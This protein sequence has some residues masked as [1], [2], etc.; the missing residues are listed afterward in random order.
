MDKAQ[1]QY[2]V[3]SLNH[4]LWRKFLLRQWHKKALTDQVIKVILPQTR[5]PDEVSVSIKALMETGLTTEL[6]DF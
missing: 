3:E 2:L 5:N 1:V 4:D 6:M